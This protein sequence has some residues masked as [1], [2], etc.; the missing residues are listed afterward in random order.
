MMSRK[1]APS[2]LKL[3]PNSLFTPLSCHHQLGSPWT[4]GFAPQR[5]FSQTPRNYSEPTDLMDYPRLIPTLFSSAVGFLRNKFFELYIIN[6]YDAEFSMEEFKR[7]AK[8]A[9]LVVSDIL[10]SDDLSPLLDNQLVDSEAYAEIKANHARMDS[11]RRRSFRVTEKEI[12]HVNLHQ[13]GIIEDDDTG[14]KAVEIMM[15]Y[16]VLDTEKFANTSITPKEIMDNVMLCNYRFYRDY[17]NKDHPSS[18]ILNV[19]NQ[20]VM[21]DQLKINM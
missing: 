3:S 13:I 9:F 10:A 4:D 6:R 15:V 5:S 7:G 17:T 16:T 1:T 18:W 14:R 12:R 2:N 20:F 21:K 19:V 11:A 8:A